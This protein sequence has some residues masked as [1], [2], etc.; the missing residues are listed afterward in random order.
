MT[1]HDTIRARLVDL[2][3]ATKGKINFYYSNNPDGRRKLWH[4]GTNWG[5]RSF[6]TRQVEAFIMGAYSTMNFYVR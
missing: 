3:H 6:T 2:E 5:E 1:R 4:V